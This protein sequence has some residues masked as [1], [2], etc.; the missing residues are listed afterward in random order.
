MVT[1]RAEV[2]AARSEAERMMELKRPVA[3]TTVRTLLSG[4]SHADSELVRLRS[5]R[6]RWQDAYC[7]ARLQALRSDS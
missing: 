3:Y 1:E 6:D 5:D 2:E 4:L 7:E